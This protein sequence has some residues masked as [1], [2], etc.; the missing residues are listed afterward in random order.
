LHSFTAENGEEV[1]R[2]SFA[3]VERRD[4]LG[5]VLVDRAAAVRYLESLIVG[6]LTISVEPFEGDVL[7]H[8]VSVVFV[9]DRA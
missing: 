1:L 9:A 8:A 6:E 4:A 2:R 7:V 5:D 3:H